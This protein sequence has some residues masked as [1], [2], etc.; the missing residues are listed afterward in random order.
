MFRVYYNGGL[1][2]DFSLFSDACVFYSI[3]PRAQ[4]PCRPDEVDGT[5]DATNPYGLTR[6]ERAELEEWL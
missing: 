1:W 3:T 5:P 4:P 6:E 2:Q